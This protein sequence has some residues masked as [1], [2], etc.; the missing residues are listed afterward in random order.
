MKIPQSIID[1]YQLEPSGEWNGR[2]VINDLITFKSGLPK[3]ESILFMEGNLQGEPTPYINILMNR[4]YA[5]ITPELLEAMMVD[6]ALTLL[7]N[8]CK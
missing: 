4:K 8:L 7:N 6:E 3:F 5:S 2:A 1:K